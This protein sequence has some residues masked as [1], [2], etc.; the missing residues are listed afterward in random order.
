MNSN[1]PFNLSE[2]MNSEPGKNFES[3]SD[4]SIFIYAETGVVFQGLV[5]SLE[6]TFAD[7]RITLSSFLPDAQDPD[8]GIGLVLDYGHGP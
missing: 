1:V 6:R 3:K 7:I 8:P 5:K 4:N 2:C